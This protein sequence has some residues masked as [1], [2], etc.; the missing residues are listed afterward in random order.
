MN[1]YQ[2]MNGGGK[3]PTGAALLPKT[4]DEPKLDLTQYIERMPSIYVLG[5]ES[6]NSIFEK[7]C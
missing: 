5:Y 7:L 6:L 1:R 3:S 4:D 2:N